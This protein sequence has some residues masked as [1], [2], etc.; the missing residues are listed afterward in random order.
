[1]K[2]V[3]VYNALGQLVKSVNCNDNTVQINV[4]DLQNGMYFVNVISNNGTMTT[5]KVSVVK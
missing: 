1:M 5:S 2:Q 3:T 4:N